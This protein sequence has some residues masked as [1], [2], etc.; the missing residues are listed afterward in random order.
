MDFGRTRQC[1][2]CLT[3]ANPLPTG[4]LVDIGLAVGVSGSDGPTTNV[5]VDDFNGDSYPDILYLRHGKTNI[6]LL[7]DGEGGVVPVEIMPLARADLH[8]CDSADG[9]NDGLVD[10]YCSVGANKGQGTGI[11]VL[12]LRRPD[13]GYTDVAEEWGVTDPYGRGRDVTFLHANNDGLPDLYIT[14]YPPRAD[15]QE[16]KNRL[17]I[18]DGGAAFIAAPEFGVDGP[19]DTRCAVTTDFDNDGDDDLVVCSEG[20]VRMY[21][22]QNGS[23]FFDVALANGFGQRFMGAAFADSDGDGDVDVVAFSTPTQFA[24][25]RLRNG[26]DAGQVF[27]YPAT[28]GHR[29]AFGDI[30]GD[31]VPDAYFVQHGC[32][33]ESEGNLP[34]IVAVSNGSGWEVWHP[35]A[36]DRGCGDGVVAFDH[37]GDGVD[38]FVVGNGRGRNG[39]LQYLVAPPPPPGC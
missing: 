20:R 16:S 5:S 39:P 27:S 24:I 23:G 11:N 22:N 38:G 2:L 1:S 8:E 12:W 36:L 31:S 13:G 35:P 28:L 7:G 25:H 4:D 10:I 18:N 29:V 17:F 33:T 32:S 21:A 9:N 15:E 37:D 26:V 30:N 14:N 19:I 34:D 6:Q 3:V